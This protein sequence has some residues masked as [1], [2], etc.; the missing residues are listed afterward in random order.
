[1]RKLWTAR[2]LFVLSAA[3]LGAVVVDERKE[4][5]AEAESLRTICWSQ[6]ETSRDGAG[7]QS[8]SGACTETRV[9]KSPR[10]R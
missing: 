9:V 4:Q 7:A 6:L 3:G 10:G 5:D 2:I 8:R 1:V